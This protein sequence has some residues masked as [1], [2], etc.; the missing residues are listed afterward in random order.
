MPKGNATANTHEFYLDNDGRLVAH[1]LGL[2]ATSKLT[3]A[4]D[5]FAPIQKGEHVFV[6][7]S[8]AGIVIAWWQGQNGE[9]VRR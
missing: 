8:D 1:F 6:R 3:R 9:I 2:R 7:S 5:A 4:Q